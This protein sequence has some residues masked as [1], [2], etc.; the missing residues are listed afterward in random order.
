MVFCGKVVR[1]DDRYGFRHFTD[2]GCLL[3]GF[4]SR[5]YHHHTEI[6]VYCMAFLSRFY[7]HHTEM[8]VCYMAFFVKVLSSPY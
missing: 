7:H 1:F 3:H 6:F 2:S 8:F 4:L 5:F